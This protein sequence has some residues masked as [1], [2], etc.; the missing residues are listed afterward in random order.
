MEQLNKKFPNKEEWV[1][2]MFLL[3]EHRFLSTVEFYL[4]LIM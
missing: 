4:Y 3:Y 1:C 2:A